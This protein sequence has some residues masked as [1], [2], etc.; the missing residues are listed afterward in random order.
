M[1]DGHVES[2][3]RAEGLPTTFVID[4]QGIIRKRFVGT[5]GQ[6]F[7]KL[8]EAVDELLRAG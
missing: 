2:A 6:K 5:T 4:R 8:Q 3:Y 7:E 1:S